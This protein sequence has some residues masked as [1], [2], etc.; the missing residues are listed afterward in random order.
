MKRKQTKLIV[1]VVNNSSHRLQNKKIVSMTV[2][3]WLGLQKKISEKRQAFVKKIGTKHYLHILRILAQP[4]LEL[5][6]IFLNQTEAKKLNFE[7]RK[8]NYATDVLSFTLEDSFQFPNNKKEFIPSTLADESISLG[9]LVMC[10][11]VLKKQ[12]KE[13]KLKFD[14]EIHY[15]ITHGLLHLLS[16]D[17][18]RSKNEENI[19]FS[20]QDEIFETRK[21]IP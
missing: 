1:S 7:H 8:K 12:A 4:K 21:L 19:M 17:H 2:N 13:H 14:E 6:L 9:E 20:I 16:L 10:P 15:M 5:N 18:E 11:Q 3:I